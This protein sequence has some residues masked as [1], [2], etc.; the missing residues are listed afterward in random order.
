MLKTDLIRALAMARSAQ[1]LGVD[2]I[3]LF[4]GFGLPGFATVSCTA[5]AL[6]QLIRWQ[7]INFDGS[8]DSPA[9]D[10]IARFGRRRLQVIG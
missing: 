4:N 6:A 10:E 2:G 7:C 9:L 8:V 1:P 5:H 3:E